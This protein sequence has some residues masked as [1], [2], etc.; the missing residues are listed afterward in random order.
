MLKLLFHLMMELRSFMLKK[1]HKTQSLTIPH[2]TLLLDESIFAPRQA[3]VAI[4]KAPSW[5]KLQ[6]T[7]FNINAIKTDQHVLK[8]YGRLQNK[9]NKN[10][11]KFALLISS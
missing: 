3:Y 7:S 2:V 8:E 1:I 9:Y 4:S 10:T 11:T 5:E 6:I